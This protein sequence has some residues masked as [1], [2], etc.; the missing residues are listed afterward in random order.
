MKTQLWETDRHGTR[1][2]INEID[3]TSRFFG[4]DVPK[5][6]ADT[7]HTADS[8]LWIARQLRDGW[9]LNGPY[10]GMNRYEIFQSRFG[11]ADFVRVE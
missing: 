1:R 4:F 5:R 10:G 3:S 6:I 9:R 2:L 8:Q 7:Q 11:D